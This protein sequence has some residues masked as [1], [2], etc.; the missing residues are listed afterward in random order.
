MLKDKLKIFRDSL[1]KSQDEM[2]KAIGVSRRGWQTYEEG[3]SV[4]GGNVFEALESLGCNLNWLFDD[5]APMHK[6]DQPTTI[7]PGEVK[8]Q[9]NTLP[10]IDAPPAM[11]YDNIGLGE[12]VELLAKI[13]NSGNTVLIR[14][15]AA[16]LH[17]FSE[18]I[19]N[20]ILAVNTVNMMKEM[21]KRMTAMEKKLAEST[22]APPQKAANG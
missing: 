13:Y 15:I 3:K 6:S 18:A 8:P 7:A 1:G 19:D 5:G 14:A 17:A 20:K 10:T 21:D 22:A 9:K 16:N 2:A 12:S 11:P 4:P